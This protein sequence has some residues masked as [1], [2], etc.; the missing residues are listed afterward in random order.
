V[1]PNQQILQFAPAQAYQPVQAYPYPQLM[2][3]RL[4]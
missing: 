4:P 3:Q 1:N 2:Y